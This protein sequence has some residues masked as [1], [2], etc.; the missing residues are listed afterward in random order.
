MDDAEKGSR[1]FAVIAKVVGRELRRIRESKGLSRT[2]MVARMPSGIGE[3]TLLSYE[4]GIRQIGLA[5]FIELCR[6][7]DKHPASVLSAALRTNTRDLEN[8]TILVDLQELAY[9][10]KPKFHEVCQWAHKRLAA[11]S[12]QFIDVEPAVVRELAVL[13]GCSHRELA[14]HLAGFTTSVEARQLASNGAHTTRNQR[15]NP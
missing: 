11:G 13:A 5:R 3:R 15:A 2:E 6:A 4:H 12:P 9:N 14:L 1:E 8:S 7:L 10:D